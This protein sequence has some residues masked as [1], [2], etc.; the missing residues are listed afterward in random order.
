MSNT[1]T[2]LRNLRQLEHTLQARLS[3]IAATGNDPEKRAAVE[4]KLATVRDQIAEAAGPA[5]L[6]YTDDEDR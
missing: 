2:N 4:E 5:R 3:L 6:P 1:P